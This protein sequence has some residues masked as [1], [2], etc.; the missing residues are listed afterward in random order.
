M[1]KVYFTEFSAFLIGA[2]IV[3]WL[4]LLV[5]EK[6][7]C[8][9]SWIRI[10]PIIR[11][12]TSLIFVYSLLFIMTHYF[13]ITFQMAYFLTAGVIIIL[14]K[15]WLGHFTAEQSAVSTEEKVKGAVQKI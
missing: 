14:N 9:L 15:Y 7:I 11:S 12:M 6:F 5:V 10:H 3:V 2:I 13:L 1:R 8:K 4:L